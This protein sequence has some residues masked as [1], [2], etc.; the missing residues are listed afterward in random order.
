MPLVKPVDPGAAGDVAG[1]A[2]D[3]RD[4]AAGGQQLGHPLRR[5]CSPASTLS[6]PM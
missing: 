2:A 6:V 1:D 5:P 4:V 3:D